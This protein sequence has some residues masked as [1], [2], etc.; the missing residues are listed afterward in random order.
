MSDLSLTLCQLHAG[1]GGE[2]LQ[3]GSLGLLGQALGL[4]RAGVSLLA[5]TPMECLAQ[6]SM[7]EK[8]VAMDMKSL[9]GG[10]WLLEAREA[11]GQGL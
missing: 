3:G 4:P 11:S 2:Q 10:E 7:L 8:A 1:H 9:K 5:L 6:D